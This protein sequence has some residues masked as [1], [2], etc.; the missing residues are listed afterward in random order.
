MLG[1]VTASQQLEW[2][3]SRSQR[4]GFAIPVH[5]DVP[6]VSVIRREIKT[7]QRGSSRVTLST[8][9]YQGHLE[10]TDPE[11]LRTTLISG[12]GRGKGYGCG[13]LTLARA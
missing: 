4:A 5:E 13:L 11:T 8:A 6:L 12:L 3:L 9:T 7:F 1:H 10:V 2:L